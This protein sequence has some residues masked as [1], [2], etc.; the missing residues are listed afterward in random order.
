VTTALSFDFAALA[1][2]LK[3][4]ADALIAQYP[5]SRSALLPLMH[6]FQDEEGYVSGDAI[7]QVAQWLGL[8]PAVVE[9]TVSFYSLFFRRPVGKYMLQPC[10]G[11]ACVIN[12][13]YEAMA[14]FRE[15]LGLAHLETSADG[16]FSYEEVECLAACDRAPCMQVNL[17]FV[18]DLTPEKIDTLVAQIRAGTFEIPALVQTKAPAKSWHVDQGAG[19]KKALGAQH[20]SD[21]NDPGGVGDPSGER[22][23]AR[24]A[25][26]PHPIQVRP[27]QERV[28]MDT[29]ALD[30]A[31]RSNGAAS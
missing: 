7:L 1:A 6:R 25:E 14:Y 27:T 3:P 18:F 9:S 8:T 31:K 28:L 29:R 10:R 22:M 17:E 20:V 30:V 5:E 21:P 13:A 12:G 26:D 23:L 19:L 11:I 2:R 15:K 4:E 24:L 16:L